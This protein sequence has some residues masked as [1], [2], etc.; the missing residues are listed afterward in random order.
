[1]AAR[2]GGDD[3]TPLRAGDEALLVSPP[4]DLE[5]GLEGLLRMD[6]G[7]LEEVLPQILDA[8][9]RGPLVMTREGRA[10]AVL[11]PLDGYRRLRTGAADMAAPAAVIEGEATARD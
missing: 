10:F 9:T 1:M 4:G 2:R 11:L 5:V 8:V 6:V 7:A 3:G